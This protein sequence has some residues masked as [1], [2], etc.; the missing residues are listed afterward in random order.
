PTQAAETLEKV[1]LPTIPQW[2]ASWLAQQKTVVRELNAGAMDHAW[3][4]FA[5]AVLLFAIACVNAMNLMLVRLFGRERELSIR[6][7]IGGSR[8]QIARLVLIESLG[9]SAIACGLV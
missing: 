1:K 8:G 7:A 3:T 2:G 5:A 4:L 9:L 6:L